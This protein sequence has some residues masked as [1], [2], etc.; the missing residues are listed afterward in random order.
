MGFPRKLYL[1]GM[2]NSPQ[3]FGSTCSLD[4]E[5]NYFLVQPTTPKLMEKQRGGTKY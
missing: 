3:N 1:I 5:Q 2:P 4:V